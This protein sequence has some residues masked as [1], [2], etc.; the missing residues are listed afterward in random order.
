MD[1]QILPAVTPAPKRKTA[2]VRKKRK[3]EWFF[4]KGAQGKKGR[5]FI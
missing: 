2:R 4:K 5:R 1:Q 3:G